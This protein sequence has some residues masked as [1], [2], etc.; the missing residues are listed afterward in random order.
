MQMGFGDGSTEEKKHADKVYYPHPHL[1]DNEKFWF[2]VAIAAMLASFLVLFIVTEHYD[3]KHARFARVCHAEKGV[4]LDGQCVTG[5][6]LIT[7]QVE[8]QIY[9]GGGQ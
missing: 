2:M 5:I 9:R 6:E 7:D 1:S 8:T 4:V 3:K